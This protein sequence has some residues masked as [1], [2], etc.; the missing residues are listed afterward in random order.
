MLFAVG[1]LFR[2]SP[3][4]RQPTMSWL[5][6][7]ALFAIVLWSAITLGFGLLLQASTTFGDTYGPLAGIV[8]LQIW[9][10]LSAIAILYGAAV[11]AQLEAV[12]AGQPEVQAADKAAADPPIENVQLD[13]TELVSVASPMSGHE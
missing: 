7:G 2:W 3:R 11:S 5:A 6:F 10:L 4:R 9:T 1:V 13:Q 8:A 12:R